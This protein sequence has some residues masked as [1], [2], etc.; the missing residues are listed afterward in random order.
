ME[1]TKNIAIPPGEINYITFRV[2][3]N[4]LRLNG[5]PEKEMQKYIFEKCPLQPTFT[6]KNMRAYFFY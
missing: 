1:V 4:S 6:L 5:K 2:I 3:V